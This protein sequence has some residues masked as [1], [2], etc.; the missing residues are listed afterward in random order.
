MERQGTFF[1]DDTG[2]LRTVWR[3][4]I[5]WSGLILI[6]IA[7]AVAGL[8]VLFI[9]HLA[10]GREGASF[11]QTIA[12]REQIVIYAAVFPNAALLVGFLVL[13]RRYL[14]RRGVLTMGLVRPRPGWWTSPQAGLTLGLLLAGV[15]ALALWATGVLAW[16]GLEASWEPLILIPVLGAAAFGEELI[17]RGYSYQNFLDIRRGT[18]GLFVTA[19]L[20]AGM[21]A[22]NP[23]VW[24]SSVPMLNLFAAG[25]LLALA[26]R[27]SGN[28]WFPTALHFGWNF[29]QGGLLRLPIS[30]RDVGGLAGLLPDPAMPVWLSGGAFGLEGSAV[31]LLAQVLLITLFAWLIHR[32]TC[33][34]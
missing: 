29:A 13:L 23:A 10:G 28:L 27:L 33:S 30:G 12:T 18:L 17:C 34:S 19:V 4:A 31:T 32:N 21:H 15:P 2:R 14:D 26:Y 5:A 16:D 24:S 22:L 9:V 6:Q 7:V 3:L 8:V 1:R 25:I 20:F 11:A